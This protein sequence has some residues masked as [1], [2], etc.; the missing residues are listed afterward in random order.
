[1][2]EAGG[3]RSILYCYASIRAVCPGDK[4]KMADTA[5]YKLGLGALPPSDSCGTRRTY[6][7]L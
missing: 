5:V 6:A 2:L 7:R 4:F 1:M 3:G